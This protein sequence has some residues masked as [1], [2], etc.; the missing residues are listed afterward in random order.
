[1]RSHQQLSQSLSHYVQDS[2]FPDEN[3][4]YTIERQPKGE[5]RGGNGSQ[6]LS[7][8]CPSSLRKGNLNTCIFV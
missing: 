4:I 2:D 1:M 5:G 8:W 7:Y 3:Y 6:T